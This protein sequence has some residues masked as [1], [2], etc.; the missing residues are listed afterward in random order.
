MITFREENGT[1]T[2]GNIP[3][4]LK[5]FFDMSKIT[6]SNLILQRSGAEKRYLI[7]IKLFTSFYKFLG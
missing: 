5:K 1:R 3:F 6:K 4:K 2:T 7:D